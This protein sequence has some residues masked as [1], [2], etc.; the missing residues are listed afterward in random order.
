M[1]RRG[2]R[3]A[4]AW[5]G[6]WLLSRRPPRSGNRRRRSGQ[7]RPATVRTG[8]QAPVRPGLRLNP[9]R[10]R[11]ARPVS[12][13]G[14]SSGGTGGGI[15]ARANLT[16]F[17]WRGPIGAAGGCGGATTPRAGQP[18]LLPRVSACP[19]SSTAC[20]PHEHNASARSHGWRFASS[21]PWQDPCAGRVGNG[22]GGSSHDQT[23]E[24]SGTGEPARV[25]C[26]AGHSLA[27]PRAVPLP[28]WWERQ[29]RGPL[30]A[31]ASHRLVPALA[32]R[33]LI[34][35]LRGVNPSANGR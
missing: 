29:C 22:R 32:C 34:R 21:G 3:T 15:R 35:I 5:P 4:N 24:A 6:P 13:Q 28:R 10:E 27:I 18:Q 8:A 1:A 33:S 23:L 17:P 19:S 11:C 2:W 25:P 12:F 7:S 16:G 26:R 9:R 14:R 31:E 30:R 20:D